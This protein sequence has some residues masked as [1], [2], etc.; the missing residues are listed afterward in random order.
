[1]FQ[2]TMAIFS[3]VSV[4]YLPV[5]IWA[6]LSLHVVFLNVCWFI[7]KRSFH[8]AVKSLFG[9]FLNLASEVVV[10]ELVSAKCFHVYMGLNAVN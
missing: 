5:N 10:L 4:L 9:K 3:Q 8:G 6:H 7:L 2:A 1:V